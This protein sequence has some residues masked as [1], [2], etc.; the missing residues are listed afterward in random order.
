MNVLEE[1]NKLVHGERNADYGHPL[2]DFECVAAAM[3]AFLRRRG[4]LASGASLD[5]RDHVMWME[6]VK[7]A[8]ECHRPKVDNRVDGAGYWETLQMCEEEAARRSER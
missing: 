1:A 5:Y 7:M 4:K 3:T 8:R 2:D 6:C